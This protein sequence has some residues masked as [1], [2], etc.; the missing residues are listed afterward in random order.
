MCILPKYK[1]VLPLRELVTQVCDQ[2]LT[3]WMLLTKALIP[4]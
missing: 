3:K 2:D 1:L 4:R